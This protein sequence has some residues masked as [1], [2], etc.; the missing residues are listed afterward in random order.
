MFNNIKINDDDVFSFIFVIYDLNVKINL[1]C[2]CSLVLNSNMSWL[3]LLFQMAEILASFVDKHQELRKFRRPLCLGHFSH[4]KSRRRPPLPIQQVMVQH[5]AAASGPQRENW[6]PLRT[7]TLPRGFCKTA[8]LEII[9]T[10][11]N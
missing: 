2:V 9:L 1:F 3:N 10:C 8:K 5:S 6:Q 4:C 11:S 7:C